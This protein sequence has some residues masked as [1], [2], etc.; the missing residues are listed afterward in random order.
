MDGLVENT[1]APIS[2][3]A[4]HGAPT[5]V[6][7]WI[8]AVTMTVLIATGALMWLAHPGRFATTLHDAFAFVLAVA[9]ASYLALLAVSGRWRT[10]LPSRGV[11]ADARAV[12]RFELGAG[13]HAPALVKY[14]GAQRLA[15]GAAILVAG[16]SVLTGAGLLFRR[17]APWLV[18]ALGGRQ[19]DTWLHI[20]CMLGI[21]AFALVHVAQVLRAGLPAL[22]GM[23]RGTE[24]VRGAAT[25]DGRALA[26]TRFV[27][28][29]APAD[30]AGHARAD[31]RRGFLVASSAAAATTLLALGGSR[32]TASL[33]GR[34]RSAQTGEKSA[35]GARTPPA[36]SRDG[37]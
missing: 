10:F 20:A 34:P 13:D 25:Y 32:L 24:P 22:A 6:L 2:S 19:I 21:L 9:G 4:K 30:A 16:G 8:N 28:V 15:Y 23:L 11:V 35:S 26:D 31:T 36:T 3:Y 1:P 17:Q 37:G 12:I 33:R 7:H 5:R 18:A 14:N 27:R 29:V